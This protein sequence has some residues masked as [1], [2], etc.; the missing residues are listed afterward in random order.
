M[1]IYIPKYKASIVGTNQEVIGYISETREYLGNGIYSGK[2]NYLIS[3]TELS[4]PGGKYGVWK[5]SKD[6]IVKP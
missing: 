1:D 5:V 6:T 2:K 3:V 4:M